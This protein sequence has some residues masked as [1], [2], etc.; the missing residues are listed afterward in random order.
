MREADRRS[1]V[2]ARSAAEA[3]RSVA[4]D[5]ASHRTGPL[6]PPVAR[7][8]LFSLG[9]ALLAVMLEVGVV[10]GRTIAV[11][12]VVIPWPVIAAGFCLA[13]IKVVPV[14]FR[15]EQ[16]S[17]SLSEFPAVIGLFLLDPTDYLLALLVGSGLALAWA[18][19]APLKLAFNVVNFGLGGAAGLSVFHILGTHL[20]TPSPADWFAAFTA[21][22][23]TTVLSSLCVATA[24]SLS[25]GAPQFQKLPQ[26]LQF[27]GLVAVANTSL[28]LLAVSILWVDWQLTWLLVVPLVT[29]F[30]A[31]RAYLSEREK[32]ERLEFLYQSGRILQHS[33][34]LDSAIV[35]LLDYARD[36]FRAELAEVLLFPRDGSGDALRTRSRD[37]RKPSAMEPVSLDADDPVFGRVQTESGAFFFDLG[38]DLDL[39]RSS[40][41]GRRRAWGWASRAGTTTRSGSRCGWPGRA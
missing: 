22:M 33:P 9:L 12:P 28:A 32:G 34:E 39:G 20:G 21:T 29:V 13:E 3:G 16:H 8:W 23:T 24:I 4:D 36:M 18:R 31:Y 41:G 37:G 17:F 10:G 2:R 38:L 1:A 14:S 35:A 25:G 7:V 5:D 27:G 26:M 11:P 6:I 19:Q 40:S 15:R 30:L